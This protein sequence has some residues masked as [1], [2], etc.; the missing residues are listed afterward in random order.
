[1]RSFLSDPVSLAN[2]KLLTVCL[3]TV[4]VLNIHK[5]KTI[6]TNYLFKKRKGKYV[7]RRKSVDPEY[8][9]EVIVSRL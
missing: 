9:L 3:R 1:M 2:N 8:M 6:V 5:E 7:K 4:F